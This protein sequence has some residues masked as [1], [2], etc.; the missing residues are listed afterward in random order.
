LARIGQRIRKLYDS[1]HSVSDR[2]LKKL[3]EDLGFMERGGKGS[4]SCYRHPNL[5]GILLT[6][7]HQNPLK[8]AYVVQVRK[9]VERLVELEDNEQQGY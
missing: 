7:P 5:P 9:I 1:P 2:E 4:H 8:I 6:V 3:L